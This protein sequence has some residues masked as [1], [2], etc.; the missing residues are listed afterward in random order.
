MK[1]SKR[2]LL[3]SFIFASAMLMNTANAEEIDLN[4]VNDAALSGGEQ[5]VFDI[6]KVNQMSYAQR[7]NNMDMWSYT[8]MPKSKRQMLKMQNKLAI[9]DNS[10]AYDPINATMDSANFWI[11][12]YGSFEDV[13]T[14]IGKVESNNYGVYFGANSGIKELDNGWDMIW[15]GYAGYTASHQHYHFLGMYQNGGTLGLETML[16][17]DNFFTGFD[18]SAGGSVGNLKIKALDV[19][20]TT[21]YLTSGVSNKTGYN[22]EL[23]DGKFIIQPNMLSSL[24]FYHTFGHS[25][26]FGSLTASIQ[27]DSLY[28]VQL[29]PGI[30]FIGNLSNGWQ[31][32]AGIS[33]VWNIA[34]SNH[35]MPWYANMPDLASRTFVKYGVG[36]KKSWDDRYSAS[37]Q[38]F[39]RNG[40]RSGIGFQ[41]G[42]NI[43]LGK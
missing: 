20:I 24:V 38:T 22:W 2:G 8:S 15:G 36:V 23:A 35:I 31:P 3:L 40:G 5:T 10:L 16:L 39:V 28:N 41:G 42:L 13:K 30:N 33:V 7:N 19:G 17:K 4:L 29:E 9:S 1:M 25:K 14:G 32:Y 6:A 11:R 27:N 18:V 12:P 34:H 26:Q 43:A 21:S 37:I